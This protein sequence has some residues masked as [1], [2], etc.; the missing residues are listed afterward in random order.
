LHL[1]AF[2]KVLPLVKN[3]GLNLQ[4]DLS[5]LHQLRIANPK[6]LGNIPLIVLTASQFDVVQRRGITDEQA[7]QDHLRLQNDL[8][9]LS[10]NSRQIV[11]S[12]SGHEIYLYKTDVVVRSISDVVSAVKN[13]RLLTATSAQLMQ[14]GARLSMSVS[15]NAARVG[16]GAPPHK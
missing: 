2:K 1:W 12:G 6:S 5:R 10:T 4:S 14:E 3:W 13:H 7:Q 11:V 15:N 9:Q 8:A 16:Q